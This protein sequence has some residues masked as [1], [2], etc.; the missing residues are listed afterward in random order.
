MLALEV[1]ALELP[2]LMQELTAGHAQE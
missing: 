2:R 1:N